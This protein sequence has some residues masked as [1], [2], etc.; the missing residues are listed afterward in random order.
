MITLTRDE[1]ILM[2]ENVKTLLKSQIHTSLNGPE[3]ES[4]LKKLNEELERNTPE[5]GKTYALTGGSGEKC[6]LNGH[7]WSESEVKK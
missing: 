5:Y 6:I 2:I 4:T 7:S 3:Y 1:I